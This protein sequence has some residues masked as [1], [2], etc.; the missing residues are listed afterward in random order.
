MT[1]TEFFNACLN[2]IVC[3]VEIMDA[4]TGKEYSGDTGTMEESELAER[5]II[6]WELVGNKFYFSVCM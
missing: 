1:V 6:N 2:A 4:N 3:D 5:E